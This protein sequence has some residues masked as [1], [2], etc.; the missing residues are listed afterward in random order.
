MAATSAGNYDASSGGG[1]TPSDTGQYDVVTPSSTGHYNATSGG[2]GGVDIQV[3]QSSAAATANQQAIVQLDNVTMGSAL[4]KI[5]ENSG[6]HQHG[7]GDGGLHGTSSDR[8]Q[9]VTY[10][11]HTLHHVNPRGFHQQQQQQSAIFSNDQHPHITTVVIPQPMSP[12][13]PPASASTAMT[14]NSTGF[15]LHQTHD[16]SQEEGHL[17]DQLESLATEQF[18]GHRIPVELSPA[19]SLQGREGGVIR[20]GKGPGSDEVMV[21]TEDRMDYQNIPESESI[22]GSISPI[23]GISSGA[24]QLAGV[25]FP[26]TKTY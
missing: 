24:E 22:S 17:R 3:L 1:V 19:A 11:Q 14:L 21:A 9:D 4:E 16:M 10:G 12:V 2:G 5:A 18:I 25:V 7:G 23:R 15:Q 26:T 8:H 13:Q 20:E 6:L